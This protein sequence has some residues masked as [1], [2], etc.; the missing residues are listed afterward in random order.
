MSCP[1]IECLTGHKALASEFGAD[2]SR[3]DGRNPYCRC[4]IRE[5]REKQRQEKRAL[6]IG[7]NAHMPKM[8]VMPDVERSQ[9]AIDR[10][11]QTRR[12]E[13]SIEIELQPEPKV[14]EFEKNECTWAGLV[15]PVRRGNPGRGWHAG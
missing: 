10:E 4:C 3:R 12:V 13:K 2:A 5:Q 9:I 6:G 1:L 14:V 8:G 11:R 7:M 15:G